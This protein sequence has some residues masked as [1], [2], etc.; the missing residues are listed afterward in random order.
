[1]EIPMLFKDLVKEIRMKCLITQ[2]ELAKWSKIDQV[3]ISHYEAGNRKPGLIA[4]KKMID[5]ANQKAGMSVK[6]EDIVSA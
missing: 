2:S 4:I 1:M 6:Y 5:V 3:S